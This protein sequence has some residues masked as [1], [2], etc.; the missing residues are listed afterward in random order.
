MNIK[1]V[2][3]YKLINEEIYVKQFLK[4]KKDKKYVC[5]LNKA[6]YDLKQFL[7]I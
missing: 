4:N 2:F 5:R 7:Q 1:I 3:L 6:L